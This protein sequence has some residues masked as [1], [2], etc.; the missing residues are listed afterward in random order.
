MITT[1]E[2]VKNI[3]ALYTT[4]SLLN[5]SLGRRKECRIDT[6]A[7]IYEFNTPLKCEN[8]IPS[9]SMLTDEVIVDV[10]GSTIKIAPKPYYRV[11]H[12]DMEGS[13]GANQ[14]PGLLYIGLYA[15]ND[16]FLEAEPEV[17]S[18][19]NNF[20]ELELNASGAE[21]VL[22]HTSGFISIL[23]NE[24]LVLQFMGNQSKSIANCNIA[25]M[26]A[27]VTFL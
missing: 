12:V 8:T 13:T 3:P 25:Y 19:L 17:K 14:I 24:E 26:R 23:E 10:D 20:I 15:S 9:T 11:A 22:G 6:I 5:T 7:S 21:D 27:I 1:S 2:L 4:S 16:R 18:N